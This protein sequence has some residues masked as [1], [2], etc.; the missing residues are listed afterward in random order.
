MQHSPEFIALCRDAQSRIQEISV[1]DVA[2]LIKIGKTPLLID[3]REQDEFTISHIPNAKHISRGIIEI[4]IHKLLH[5]KDTPAILYCGGGNR[6]ALVAD[7]LQCMGYTHVQSM[8]GGF[9][10][11]LAAN[12][13]VTSN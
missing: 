13:P 8:S 6:S 3:T 1:D 2:E 12:N 10:Q 9:R 4:H 5:N 11:W 7:S